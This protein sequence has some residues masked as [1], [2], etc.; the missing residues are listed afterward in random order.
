MHQTRVQVRNGA[1]ADTRRLPFTKSLSLATS[2]EEGRV[3]LTQ[4]HKTCGLFALTLFQPGLD[5]L[6]LC[7]DRA[8]IISKPWQRT[9]T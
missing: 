5:L 8:L 2:P 1:V 3:W 6:M 7:C 4:E 9:E